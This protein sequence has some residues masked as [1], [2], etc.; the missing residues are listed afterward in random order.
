MPY[1]MAG[2]EKFGAAAD[3]VEGVLAAMRT[4]EVPCTL[5]T[6]FVPIGSG[7]ARIVAD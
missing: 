5:V 6:A 1:K 3:A 7:V 4:A 2:W